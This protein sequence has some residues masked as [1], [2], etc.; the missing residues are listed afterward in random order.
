[1]RTAYWIPI[2]L[3]LGGLMGVILHNVVLWA[4]AGLV[5]GAAVA[6]AQSRR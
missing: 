4:G 3:V 6:A 5:L 1:M 2:G